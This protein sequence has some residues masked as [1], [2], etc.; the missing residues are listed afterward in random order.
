[1]T[2][3]KLLSHTQLGNM[4]RLRRHNV[5]YKA[6][7]RGLR[8]APGV[9]IVTEKLHERVSTDFGTGEFRR[10]GLA[11]PL[12]QGPTGALIIQASLLKGPEHAVLQHAAGDSLTDAADKQ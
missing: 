10:I 8:K 12:H 9:T 5:D 4:A 6:L 7:G 2:S 11:Q 3:R 1:M